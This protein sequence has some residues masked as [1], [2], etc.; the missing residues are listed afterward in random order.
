MTEQGT[1]ST[2][3]INNVSVCCVKMTDINEMVETWRLLLSYD[4]AISIITLMKKAAASFHTESTK[5]CNSGISCYQNR[6]FCQPSCLSEMTKPWFVLLNANNQRNRASTYVISYL[7]NQCV[8]CVIN[9]HSGFCWGFWNND[10]YMSA[11]VNIISIIFKTV[12]ENIQL[13][14]LG[15]KPIKFCVNTCRKIDNSDRAKKIE[16]V[17]PNIVLK[18]MRQ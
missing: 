16:C 10:S 11:R 7:P 9:T 2:Y 5:L 1:E 15:L 8:E 17:F 4:D 14:S 13:F 12:L 6:L 18:K 3:T